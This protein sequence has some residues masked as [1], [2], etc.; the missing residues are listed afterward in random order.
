ME[1][2][3]LSK[4]NLQ[5]W[6]AP[7]QRFSIRKY[8]FGA[9]SVLLGVA[10]ALAGGAE[11]SALTTDTS[12]STSPSTAVETTGSTTDTT[13]ATTDPSTAT[14][15]TD[16]TTTDTSATTD[17]ATT[18]A[19][20]E[21]TAT[22]DYTVEYVD[23]TGAVVATVAKSTTTTTTDAVAIA[24]VTETAELPE[25]YELAANE[26]STTIAGVVEGAST[27]VVFKVT[28]QTVTKTMP[29]AEPAASET[30][31]AE[32][33]PAP[34]VVEEKQVLEQ[35]TSEAAV[36]ASEGERLVATTEA[37]NAALQAA[38]SDAKL[39]ATEAQATLADSLATLDQINAQI[40]AVR[41]KVEALAIELR[42]L[43]AD[44]EITANLA[45]TAAGVTGDLV[46]YTDYVKNQPQIPNEGAT[47]QTILTQNQKDQIRFVEFTLANLQN[48]ASFTR[49]TAADGKI[50]FQKGMIF[51]QRLTPGL[52]VRVTVKDLT[53]FRATDEY[54]EMATAIDAAKGT[55]YATDV[56]NP[57]AVNK[58]R[59]SSAAFEVYGYSADQM[60]TSTLKA[61]GYDTGATVNRIGGSGDNADYGVRLEVNA[62]SID[63]ATGREVL[64]PIDVVM[65]DGEQLTSRETTFFTTNGGGWELFGEASNGTNPRWLANNADTLADGF[66]K[67]LAL[68]ATQQAQVVWKD[69]RV[70]NPDL[71]YA[72]NLE[73]PLWKGTWTDAHG[74]VYL[75]NSN[76][77]AYELS[78]R[79]T[80][81]LIDGQEVNFGY[82]I[83][84]GESSGEWNRES[85][86]PSLGK[87]TAEQLAAAFIHPNGQA[88]LGTNVI[89]GW[90][91]TIY[92]VP[93]GEIKGQG[94][95]LNLTSPL[96]ITKN[97]T[98]V[99]AY[100]G[101]PGNQAIMIGFAI[102]DS[103]DA[104]DS[105]GIARHG[106]NPYDAANNSVQQPY[107][108]VTPADMENSGDAKIDWYKDDL[109]GAA[110]EGETQLVGNTKYRI[111]PLSETHHSLT[112]TAS[113][114]GTETAYARAWLDI[115]KNG[116]FD[117]FEAS[118]V[119]T[120]TGEQ[121]PIDFIFNPGNGFEDNGYSVADS[122][123]GV[124]I[125][126]STNRDDILNPIGYA[127]NGEVEDFQ[128]YVTIPP[129]GSLKETTDLQGETQTGKVDFT[130][131]GIDQTAYYNGNVAK[132]N[133]IDTTIPAKIVDPATGNV[134][135]PVEMTITE[136]HNGIDSTTTAKVSYLNV[137]GEGQYYV[138][139]DGRVVFTPEEG[140]T[141]VAQGIIVR[142]VDTNG[143]ST[144]WTKYQEITGDA[145]FNPATA[146][147]DAENFNKL[148]DKWTM[149]GRYIP[150]VTPVTPVATDVTSTG[151][152]GK[153][154]TGTPEFFGNI[155]ITKTNPDGTVSKLA[156]PEN[157]DIAAQYPGYTVSPNPYVP[158]D[159]TVPATFA[160][161]TTTQTIENVGTYTVAADGTVTFT[162]R[163][164][165][166]GTAPTVEVVRVDTNGT[167]AVG[168]YTPT[169]TPVTPTS[170]TVVSSGRQGEVQTGTVP[171][172]EGHTEVPM[173]DTV[174]ATF[175][176]GT[177]EKTVP[178]EGTYTVAP[179]GKVTFTPE[180]NFIGVAQGVKVVRV[181]KNGT[182]A[183]GQYIPTVTGDQTA[184][185]NYR[186]GSET[187][188]LL[189]DS[190][191]LTGKVGDAISADQATIDAL[192]AKGYE[193]TSNPLETPGAFD[194][195]KDTPTPSQTF[196]LIFKEKVEPITDPL[197]PPTPDNPTPGYP[198]ADD[199]KMS[200]EVTRTIKYVYE[201]GTE[202]FATVT[203]TK[204]FTRTASINMVTG[205]ITYGEWTPA[206]DFEAKISPLLAGYIADIKEDP[207]RTVNAEDADIE[208]VVTYKKLGSWV[209]ELPEGETPVPPITYPNDPNEDPTIPGQP[210]PTP[211]IPEIPG[212]VPV[213]PDGNEL[214]KDPNTGQY[215][216]PVPV[217]PTVDTPIRYVKQE[218][219]ATI[220]FVNVTDPANPVTLVT[221][222]LDGVTGDQ[223]GYDT[224]T[225]VKQYENQGFT[226]TNKDN[227]SKDGIYSADPADHDEFVFE[228]VERV[229]PVDPTDPKT[230]GTPVDPTDPDGPKWP[231]GVKESDLN[232]T[233]TRTINY[234]YADGT[235]VLDENGQPRTFTE[236]LTFTRT[237]TVNLVTGKV[238]YSE[239]AAKDSDTTFGAVTS[240]AVTNYTPS[241]KVVEERANVKATDTDETV[242]VIYRADDKQ[243][244]TVTYK[245]ESGTELA[246]DGIEGYAGETIGYDTT[247]KIEDYLLKGY[248][249]VSDGYTDALAADKV[250][251]TTISNVQN[252]DV[253]LREKVTPITP[254][255][256]GKPGEPIDP[257]NPDGPKWPT[258]QGVDDTKR[259]ITRDVTYVDQAGNQ[260]AAPSTQTTATFTRTGS[261]N[262]V[263][264][265]VTWTDWTST[266]DVLEGTANPVI[267]GYLAVSATA[268]G[269]DV[270]LSSVEKDKTVKYNADNIQEVVTY[271]KLSEWI[272]VVPDGETPVPPIPYP[273]HPTEPTKPGEPTPTP[274][275]PEIPGYVPVGPDGNELPKDPNTG[276]YIPPV[277]VDP[278]K[279]TEIT[280]VAQDQKATVN[281]VD[282]SDNP[283]LSPVEL[284]GKSGE[285]INY[286]TTPTI[287]ELLK[288]GYVLVTDGFPAGATYD[289]DASVPQVYTVVLKEKVVPVDPTD[290]NTPTPKPGEPVD[291]TDP[292]SPVWPDSV[293]DL[294]TTEEVTRTITYVDKDGKTVFKTVTETKEFTR[295]AEIN[296]VTGVITYGEWTP[297]QTFEDV[298]SPLLADH[299]VDTPVVKGQDVNP[300]DPDINVTVVYT[301]LGSWVPVVPPGFPE[302]PEIVYPVDPEDPTKPGTD[303]PT[304]PHIPGT[305]PVTPD[306]ENPGKFIPLTPVDPED[307][308]KGYE[309]P[310]VPTD[311]TKDTIIVYVEDTK[312]LAI[313]TI[314]DESTGKTLE[315]LVEQGKTGTTV[316][317]NTA[318]KLAEL[319]KAGYIVT[320]DE[321]N[322]SAKVYDNDN[323]VNQW[324]IKVTPR[325]EPV[326][327]T[328]PN[329]PTP[330]PGEP[331]DPTDPNSPVWP[332]SVKDLVTTQEVV[333]TITY[334]NEAG[335]TVATE[336]VQKVNFTRTAQVNL[337]TGEIT[338]GEWTP[339]QE[340]PAQDSPVVAGYYT[341]TPLVDP[342]TV[343]AEDADVTVTVV[344]K[345]LG[346][347]IPNIPGQPV[348]PL[349]Y[350]NDP[351]N[352]SVPGQPDVVI[353]YVPG[354][355]PEDPNGNPLTPVDPED[356]TKGYIPPTPENPGVDTPINYTPNAVQLTVK[357]V[358]ENGNEL[359]PT[360]TS[361]AQVGDDYT[362]TPKVI[363]G[364][365]LVAIP[366]NQNG[367]VGAEGTTVVYV[368]KKLGNWIPQIPGEP[369]NPL[370]YPNHPT[371]PSKPGVPEVVIPYVPGYVPVDPN[372]NPLTPVDPEDPSKGYIPPTP[373]NPGVDT[374]ITY[375]PVKPGTPVVPPTKP[376]RPVSPETPEV[377]ARPEVP[378]QP[379]QPANPA[380]PAGPV[381][382]QLPNTGESSSVAVT[383]I[384]AS[385]LLAA[386]ALAG[387]RRRQ[388]EE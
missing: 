191:V 80:K 201:D 38:T 55:T 53:P 311:P 362:T 339:A 268:N 203:E 384:G 229:L 139:E 332:D 119:V 2:N 84:G 324:T 372:G 101:G 79:T 109:A 57:N 282:E 277:P 20:A 90:T 188:A 148:T 213:G 76:N 358:D 28:K 302:V 59:N 314:V 6:Y 163:P 313:V 234:V 296:L 46:S 196:N 371:D 206:Q 179:D 112:V 153:P 176:D 24:I 354:Y 315:T 180:D 117:A 77:E 300:T 227:Y 255:T 96:F 126:I 15:T 149:D 110:D 164:T 170:N 280:Y 150:T 233:V 353:P 221:I 141:G 108:G 48:A 327:P 322:D 174:P 93:N 289:K 8:H 35:V 387:K 377:P 13:T 70:K 92:T 74:T 337:V 317:I 366:A 173:D 274:G 298:T 369:V 60:R 56:Y 151:I 350:P 68:N 330:K 195:V 376:E 355:T 238:T 329:T 254:D 256:P 336:V 333:R 102:I 265:V 86:N 288:K 236:V 211:G 82:P 342:A 370:P 9:A 309:V 25:G 39:V 199:I 12:T 128:I 306:P 386:L 111:I 45:L 335:E 219:Q 367:T 3:Y 33:T 361:E 205:A 121:Q 107:F 226:V 225:L 99:G 325:I 344:Y 338:Y 270:L 72:S 198:T 318:D 73:W 275:I 44:G 346:N 189:A 135:E 91:N 310:P 162:P 89:G 11:A 304:V 303:V 345:K 251:D 142:R 182:P 171:F 65:G 200:E 137:L 266:D 114:G 340:L 230:P 252:F 364:Y 263:T 239:W 218:Q 261:I 240:P 30:V 4:T 209:P 351:E 140:F 264:G 123:A 75:V 159:T 61:N 375:I 192:L 334:V 154:Q 359:V 47:A 378:A 147:Q 347:W 144:N 103:G 242:T 258:D 50:I 290:P 160:D 16:A 381:V 217:D 165:F 210:T 246:K 7:Q 291:P 152:Q 158:I 320:S 22:I 319:Q 341:E 305:T 284:T 281:Y 37:N 161:G 66:R 295:T 316:G 331:V 62:V 297:V 138:Y 208:V 215:I 287:E 19:V 323:N 250:F 64:R 301:P 87:Y 36:L 21:R 190:N 214:P 134:I 120:V 352:P 129:K 177:T 26:L 118:E 43:S 212:Y 220:T 85:L 293:K 51:E 105:Y 14:S 18:E 248:E 216:P 228:L 169:V 71:S 41:A 269:E 116:K 113:K 69:I 224:D 186:L 10:L 223:F 380:A 267:P 88:G 172:T 328:D 32:Q 29:T 231:D 273:N 106:A 243:L 52:V 143:Q 67:S 299:L 204:D 349:P 184:L 292:N 308:S 181:D 365:Y 202:A 379:V 124:R 286:S 326:D 122:R 132:P 357:Y 5:K 363:P 348:N 1:K 23:E 388:E 193:L 232:E 115:N 259:V 178:G 383:A 360:E 156:V 249:L 279:P 247:P 34:E 235:P 155:L 294:V 166:T 136:R 356:P 207:T 276:L 278:T 307:P 185:I 42:K 27:K 95:I 146:T 272:P 157:T 374:P 63:P 54:L 97:A 222:P 17:T 131:Y 31:V 237:A 245:T 187:G 343:N 78:N 321:Y 127:V 125:R 312:Q 194:K 40:D 104:P 262:H 168:T 244:A 94:G 260:I 368:Y 283:I 257:N 98:E 241:Q 83:P 382:D 58:L 167:K 271:V 49:P 130:A 285:V 81:A 145:T 183:T 253:I 197:N 100:I 133:T 175:D 385:M 373:E